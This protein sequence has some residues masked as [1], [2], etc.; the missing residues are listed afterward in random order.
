MSDEEFE[1]MWATIAMWCLMSDKQVRSTPEKIAER[2][3][4]QADAMVKERD[5]RR[6]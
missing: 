6:E 1:D 2:A 4:K 5:K 3:Y